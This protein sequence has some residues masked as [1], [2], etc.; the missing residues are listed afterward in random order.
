MGVGLCSVSFAFAV[1]PT[2]VLGE[3]LSNPWEV[4]RKPRNGVN[5]AG[6]FTAQHIYLGYMDSVRCREARLVL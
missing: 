3:G 6:T 1:F 5:Q 2:A 4:L